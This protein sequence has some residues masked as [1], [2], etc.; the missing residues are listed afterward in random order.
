MALCFMFLLLYVRFHLLSLLVWHIL[1]FLPQGRIESIQWFG[2]FTFDCL[3]LSFTLGAIIR[4]TENVFLCVLFHTLTNIGSA[5][6]GTNETLL[7]SVLLACMLIIVSFTA[8]LV[9]KKKDRSS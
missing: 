1:V 2:L 8:V 9:H 6:F 4:I 3:G 5:M 7:G